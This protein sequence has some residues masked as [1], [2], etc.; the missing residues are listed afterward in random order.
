MNALMVGI[1]LSIGGVGAF[2]SGMLGIGGSIII[3]PMLLLI[4]PMLH[5]GHF[6]AQEVSTL[7]MIQVLFGALGG[8]LGYRKQGWLHPRLVMDM[9]VSIMIGSFAGAYGSGFLP[10]H[11]INLLFG[12]LVMV[13][14]VLMLIPTT[15]EKTNWQSVTEVRYN[16]WWAVL[17]AGVVGLVSGVVGAGGAFIL[18]PVMI[19]VLR[20]PM[21]VSVASSLAIVLLSAIGGAVGKVMTGQV[22]WGPAAALV[23]GSLLGS[24][25]GAWAGGKMETRWLRAALAILMACSA[26]EIWSKILV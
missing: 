25:L 18:V 4:P 23:I 15:G 10:D 26:V 24:R 9:G 13:A 2:L 17:I 12:I 11:A 19:V 6:S 22:T 1:L 5:A 21:R 3:Y 20:I 7:T 16:R 14:V 8:V